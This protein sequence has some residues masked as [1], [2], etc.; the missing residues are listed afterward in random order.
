MS[1]S[2][3]SAPRPQRGMVLLSL[4][5]LIIII[6]ACVALAVYMVHLDKI[7]REKFEGQRW[8]IPAKVYARPLELFVGAELSPEELKSEL[9]MLN[10]RR[11]DNYDQTGTWTVSGNTWFVH[12]RGFDFDNGQEPEQ[13]LKIEFQGNQIIDIQSTMQTGTGMV[14]L[15]PI[16][17]GGIYPRHNEDRVLVQLSQVPQ[18]LIDALIATEDRQFYQHNGIS[19]RG[20]ARALVSTATG[21]ERQGGSTLTQQLVKNFYLTSERTLKRKANEA[22]MAVLLELHYNKNDI[23]ETYLNEINLGQ[24]GN[25]AIHGFG[26]AAQFYFNQPLRE[27]KLHQMALL[28]GIV[29]GP[30]Q[31]N[32]WRNPKLALERRNI[33]LH[34]MLLMGKISQA[35]YE[36]AK[37]QPLTVVK[38]PVAGKSLFPDFLD[39]VRRQL[40]QQYQEADLSSDGLK[41]F[42]TLDPRVQTAATRAFDESINR[43]TKRNPKQLNGLQGAVVISN[44]QNG[45]LVAVVGGSGLFTGFNRAL[46]ASRQIGS[47]VK[48]AI[49]LNALQ[50]QRYNLQSPLD[51]SP[52]SITGMGLTDWTPKNYDHRDHGVIPLTDALAYSYNQSTVRLGWELGVPSVSTTLR[53]LGVDSDIPQYPSMLLGAI[54]LTPIQVL[55]MYQTYAAHGFG[56][57]LTAIR[58]VLDAR[59]QPLQRY[60]FN[61]RQRVDSGSAY[62]INYALQQVVIKGTGKAAQTSLAPELNLAGKTGTTNDA[63]DAWFAGYSGNYTT[64]VWLGHDDNR[65]IGLSGSTGALP[66]WIEVMRRLKLTPVAPQQPSNVQWQWID[67]ATGNI[68]AQGCAG[69]VFIP[70]LID[71]LPKEFTSCAY[72]YYQNQN[73]PT[74]T[75]DTGTFAVPD[76]PTPAEEGNYIRP[77]EPDAADDTR[78]I[79]G[80]VF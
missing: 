31:Y 63:R 68:S 37:E 54:N 7:V 39:V 11:M 35:D 12:T 58:S 21:G 33:V 6:A 51:D 49:Y 3:N 59:N 62:L 13:V 16:V 64:V 41:I 73:I 46:D 78:G 69:A 9:T 52:I 55:N 22:L 30:S 38:K 40:A 20:T 45:E 47:L 43:L 48:P 71:S 4:I 57:P 76:T 1:F 27:L 34:N 10:Y 32:P 15:E 77:S 28:V 44:P 61:V 25:R 56:Y 75:D 50:T 79:F 72:N 2:S 65:P 5:L 17:I 53:Q 80:G 29:K 23:L 19:I 18:P 24:N 14:R 66:V 8:E 60:G 67:Q 70:M 42:S 74:Y 26:L 36:A